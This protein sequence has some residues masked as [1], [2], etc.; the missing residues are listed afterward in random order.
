MENLNDN[1][2][3]DFEIPEDSKNPF[4][5]IDLFIFE[6]E[7]LEEFNHLINSEDFPQERKILILSKETLKIFNSL[8]FSLDILRNNNFEEKVRM[9]EDCPFTVEGIYHLVFLIPPKVEYINIIGKQLEHNLIQIEINTK[10]GIYKNHDTYYHLILVPKKPQFIDKFIEDTEYDALFKTYELDFDA[11]PLDYDILSLENEDIFQ[12]LF[13]KENYESLSNLASVILRYEGIFGKIKNVY[14]K[15]YYSQILSNIINKRRKDEGFDDYKDSGDETLACIMFDRN[16]DYI[17]PFA[18]EYIYEGLIDEII[19]IDYNKIIIDSEIL[20]ENSKNKN[21]KN[22]D[23]ILNLSNKE[24]FFTMIKDYH[25]DKIRKFLPNRLKQHHEI[26]DTSKKN[27]DFNKMEENLNL[28]MV[29]TDESKKLMRHISIADY[30]SKII[31]HPSYKKYIEF[32]QILL[33]SGELPN[34]LH[35]FIEN[36]MSKKVNMY[37]ILRLICLESIVLNGI[38]N[39]FYDQI[40]KDFINIYGYQTI[41]LIRKLEKLKIL[42]KK[43]NSNYNYLKDKLKLINENVNLLNPNDSSYVLGGFCPIIIRLIENLIEKGWRSI[44]DILAKIP[45]D[46][47]FP[48]DEYEVVYPKYEINYILLVFVGGI[49]YSELAAIRYLNKKSKKYKFLIISDCMINNKKIFESLN[50]QDFQILRKLDE[51]PPKIVKEPEKL[52]FNKKDEKEKKKTIEEINKEIEDKKKEEIF[53]ETENQKILELKKKGHLYKNSN[54]T[55]FTMAKCAKDIEE[56][57]YKLKK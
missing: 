52:F 44:K 53:K 9:I 41:F 29:I 43:E 8:L 40:K 55:I 27:N 14:Y 23:T 50:K 20:E 49:T 17:T 42:R 57:K 6:E 4:E 19:G 45:G 36:E 33:G 24:K 12:E 7:M 3:I 26:L 10:K 11:F 2:N 54:N 13:V 5:P 38:K 30:L 31:S 28:M 56:E 1:N 18:S 46:F 51:E 37:K 15:G 25:F 34:G 35:E 39:K 48:A 32:E 16:I 47:N 22:K 21:N